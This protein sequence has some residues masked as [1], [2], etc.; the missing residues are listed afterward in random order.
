MNR[1]SRR[2]QIRLDAG[3]LTNLRKEE[4]N[5]VLRGADD[6]VGRGGRNLLKLILR[7]SKAKRVRELGLDNSPVH[8]FF[9]QLGDEEV[10]QR[11]DWAILN[12]YL[13]VFY[14]GRLPLLE[15]TQK[16]WEIERENYADELLSGFDELLR[17]GPPYDMGYLKD[18]D[19][20]MILLLL[21]KVESTGNADYVPL[22]KAWRETDYKKVRQ[23]ISSVIRQ[24]LPHDA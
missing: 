1:K 11:I 8:G 24:L 3:G 15:Y 7:G 6:I 5:A 2:V 20:Q 12:G 13:S 9:S 17:R 22:L 19:R 4:L 14:D 21:E 18:R 10:M 16:G 23:R